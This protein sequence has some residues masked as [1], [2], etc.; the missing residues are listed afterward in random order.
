[1]MPLVPFSYL[2]GQ[3]DTAQYFAAADALNDRVGADCLRDIIHAGHH[4]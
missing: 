3:T 1:M 2:R 4:A